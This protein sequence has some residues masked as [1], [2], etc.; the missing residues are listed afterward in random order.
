LPTRLED[1]G[2]VG[3]KLGE[4]L[5]RCHHENLREGIGLLRIAG[6][7]PDDV[8]RFVTIES[9]DWNMERFKDAFDERDCRE[10][11]LGIASRCAL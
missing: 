3:D 9:E 5:V 4:V 7:R 1:P 6:D 8:I 2:L 11:L 10:K